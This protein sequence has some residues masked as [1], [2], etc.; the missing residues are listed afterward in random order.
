MGPSEK[1]ATKLACGLKWDTF[2]GPVLEKNVQNC[3]NFSGFSSNIAG[4]LCNPDCV[5]EGEGFEP[6]VRFPVQRF[7]RPPVSTTHTSLRTVSGTPILFYTRR[8]GSQLVDCEPRGTAVCWRA[9]VAQLSRFKRGSATT[10]DAARQR[11]RRDGT[12][13]CGSSPQ[14][15][16]SYWMRPNALE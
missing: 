13:Y 2:S 6:P 4:V 15:R 11:I 5:A 3:G 12:L 16:D 1:G 9:P 14:L 10:H 8:S 7:S